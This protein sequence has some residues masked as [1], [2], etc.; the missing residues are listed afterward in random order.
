MFTPDPANAANPPLIFYVHADHIDTPRVVVDRS[1]NLRWR[2][3][4][5]PFGTTA[6]ENN[7]SGLGS[8]TQN[9]RFP[10]QYA[11]S[12]SGLFYNWFRSLDT[13][14]SRYTQPDPI[15]LA[16]GDV[17]L[18]SY[19][20][21]NPISLV[22]PYGLFSAAD[23]PTIPQPAMDFMMGVADDLSFGLGPLARDF[24]GV[25]GGVNRCSTAYKAGQYGALGLGLGRMAYAGTAKAVSM[26][27]GL[28]GQEAS[29]IRNGMKRLFRGPFAGSNYR[30]YSYE[31]MLAEKGSDA[32]VKAA[33]G[34]TSRGWN[35][36]G[37]DAGVGGAANSLACGCP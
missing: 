9:L 25:D 33:A 18:H 5:E 28:T 26:A 17:S 22:D 20:G 4:A 27:S 10:G 16:G 12:E 36:P 15:G 2:W 37:I 11:D 19:V 21:G 31:Q 3:M 14:T 6:P 35:A 13:T 34:R 7:P 29:A 8:F 32:A 23:L 30:I 1:N 24:L